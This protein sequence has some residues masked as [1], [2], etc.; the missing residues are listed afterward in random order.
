M[1]ILLL[2]IVAMRENERIDSRYIFLTDERSSL[3]RF[4][5][6]LFLGALK[7]AKARKKGTQVEILYV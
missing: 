7:S 1:H 3:L 5:V 4:P 2:S 6:F